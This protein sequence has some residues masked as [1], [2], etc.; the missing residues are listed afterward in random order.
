MLLSPIYL[1]FTLTGWYLNFSKW[2]KKNVL[3]GNKNK[4]MSK[5][6]VWS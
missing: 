4:I 3:L 5:I 6:Q 1:T 2:F